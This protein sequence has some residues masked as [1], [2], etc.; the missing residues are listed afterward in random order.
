MIKFELESEEAMLIYMLD[1]FNTEE[2]LSLIVSEDNIETILENREFECKSLI[3]EINSDNYTYVITKNTVKNG[4]YLEVEPVTFDE[5]CMMEN[6]IENDLVV[7]QDGLLD[8]DDLLDIEAE[9]IIILDYEY[10]NEEACN[11][12]CCQGCCENNE[13]ESKYSNE[14]L[15]SDVDKSLRKFIDDSPQYATNT[16]INVGKSIQKNNI[17]NGLDNSIASLEYLKKRNNDEEYLDNEFDDDC[18]GDCETC[19]GC[20][21]ELE[22]ITEEDILNYIC[23]QTSKTGMEIG[24]ALQSVFPRLIE[25]KMENKLTEF[26]EMLENSDED[27]CI[28]CSIKQ[29]LVDTYMEAYYNGVESGKATVTEELED[30]LDRVSE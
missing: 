12:E 2:D 18:L 9:E 28:H 16:S 21:E 19:T 24:E 23:E 13:V 3:K 1:R 26:E 11:C 27:I 7:V 5:D 30:L 22:E 14:A 10:D 8:E 6:Y 29:M 25:Q 20:E 15:L 17:L 4:I